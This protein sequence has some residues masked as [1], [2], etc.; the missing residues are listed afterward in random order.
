MRSQT[1]ISFSRIKQPGI[2]TRFDLPTFK[3]GKMWGRRA[4]HYNDSS[5][6]QKL[7]EAFHHFAVMFPPLSPSPHPPKM[8]TPL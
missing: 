1:R 4:I 3:Q 8:K 5:T 6:Y 7:V 2:V